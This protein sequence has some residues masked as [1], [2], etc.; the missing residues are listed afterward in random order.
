M[1]LFISNKVFTILAKKGVYSCAR[2]VQ[3]GGARVKGRWER[4]F[5]SG[6]SRPEGSG[7]GCQIL[8]LAQAQ[9]ALQGLLGYVPV[10]SLAQIG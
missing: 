1:V 7:I 8:T 10:S 9:A 5:R 2:V 3:Q 4:H 6:E